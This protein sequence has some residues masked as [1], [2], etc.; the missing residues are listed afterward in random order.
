M[1]NNLTKQQKLLIRRNKYQASIKKCIICCIDF[2][3]KANAKNAKICFSSK[4]KKERAKLKK[5]KL[6]KLTYKNC[7]ICSVT[8]IAIGNTTTCSS[9]CSN[10]KVLNRVNNRY[11]TDIN[12]KLADILRSRLGHAIKNDQKIGSAVN[13]LGCSI[14]KLKIYLESLFQLGMSWDNYGF[15]GWHIDHIEP[16]SKFN[17]L[18]RDE[19]LIAC[20][21]TNLQP[22]WWQDNIK[23]SNK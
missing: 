7:A 9:N 15:R 23:K 4:C 5:E 19:L 10:I 3:V 2:T 20:H 17:L 12:F 18:N 8:F 1:K 21:Y 6:K 16:L 11:N 14:P 13:D 22:L